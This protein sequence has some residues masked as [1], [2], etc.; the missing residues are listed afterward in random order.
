ME[1]SNSDDTE[2]HDWSTMDSMQRGDRAA[3]AASQKIGNNKGKKRPAVSSKGTPDVGN[4]DSSEGGQ[5]MVFPVRLHRMLSII[6]SSANS[7]SSTEGRDD[8]PGAAETDASV[9]S[10]QP[11]G[12]CFLVHDKET[13]VKLFLP[14]YVSCLLR[15]TGKGFD[16]VAP[17]TYQL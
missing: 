5:S 11:H 15:L 14:R 12:R 4:D 2:H 9:V 13:F 8:A 6:D 10:W 7:S 3:A 1:R 17:A 16:L